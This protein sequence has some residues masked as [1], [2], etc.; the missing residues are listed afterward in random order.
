[1]A[2]GRHFRYRGSLSAS[3]GTLGVTFGTTQK[4]QKGHL[5]LPW[6]TFEIR[7][8]KNLKKPLFWD[9]FG[10]PNLMTIRVFFAIIFTCAPSEENKVKM[11]ENVQKNGAQSTFDMH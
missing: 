11:S 10:D 3:L 5:G 9:P 8:Q 1:M 4:H 2:T 6:R 7:H